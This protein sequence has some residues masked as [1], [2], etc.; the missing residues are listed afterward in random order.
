MIIEDDYDGEFRYAGPPIA[1]LKSLDEHGNVIYV[2]TASKILFPALRLGWMVLPE[3]LVPIFERA[4][5]L[6]DASPATLEQLAFAEFIGHGHLER[7]IQRIRKRYA[8]KRQTLLS[9]IEKKLGARAEV[10][11]SDAGIHIVLKLQNIAASQ[12]QTLIAACLAKSVGVYAI[13]SYYSEAH[14]EP[15]CELMLGYAAL[16]E[17]EI[18]E[19]ISRLA[20]VVRNLE[21]R[22]KL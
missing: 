2:G 12:R 16:N 10:V 8:S 17:N 20:T 19:G 5:V 4:K 3:S 9:S 21:K 15:A 6:A 18:A 13:S 14:R 7:H 22:A 1:S 11:G